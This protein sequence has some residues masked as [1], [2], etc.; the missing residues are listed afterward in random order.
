MTPRSVP[1]YVLA[2]DALLVLVDDSR[3]R[4]NILNTCIVETE[5]PLRGTDL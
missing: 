5:N 3:M 2:L 1:G 4:R